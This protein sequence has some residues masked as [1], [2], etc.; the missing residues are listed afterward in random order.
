MVFS[1]RIGALNLAELALETSVHNLLS[2][3][4]RYFSYVTIVSFIYKGKKEWETI[5]IFEAHSASMTDFK[6]TVNFQR[7]GISI[8]VNIF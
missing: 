7:E 5:A 8:P 3:D 2:L 1:Y 6:S 4:F